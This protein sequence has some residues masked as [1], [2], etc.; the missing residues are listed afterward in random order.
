[1]FSKFLRAV[2][3]FLLSL[4]GRD[5]VTS[6]PVPTPVTPTLAE[7]FGVPFP[8]PRLTIRTP[9]GID[10]C[11][12]RIRVALGRGTVEIDRDAARETARREPVPLR[13]RL[14]GRYK[15]PG[16]LQRQLL[17]GEL[18]PAGSGSTLA[19][20]LSPRRDSSG[21]IQLFSTLVIAAIVCFTF[22]TWLTGPTG[23]S[24]FAIGAIAIILGA[25]SG[26]LAQG[27]LNLRGNLKERRR[28]T[29]TAA[30]LATLLD[31]RVV[32]WP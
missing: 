7:R 20:H 27:Y 21:P 29:R 28:L 9:L 3:V 4:L 2:R 17:A 22:L 8:Q 14:T 13:I 12:E 25:I 19:L 11:A 16:L 5:E 23:V 31:G 6:L 15:M 32:D 26:T 18:I 30:R 1:M 24:L 10:E